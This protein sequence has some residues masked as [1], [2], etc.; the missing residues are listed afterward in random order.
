MQS[1]SSFVIPL[2]PRPPRFWLLKL[3]MVI[4]LIYPSWVIAMTVF[5]RLIRSS[6]VISSSS[7]PRDVFLSS[8]YLSRISLISSRITPRSSFS[9]ARIAFNSPI[10]FISSLYSF[11]IFSLS[12]PVK[13]LRRISTMAWAWTSVRPNVSISR[14]LASATFFD[15]RIM[16]ITSSIWSRA[17]NKPCKICARSSALF[18]SKRVLRVTTSSWCFR[19][20]SSICFRFRIIGWLLTSANMITPYVSC[21]WVCLYS[22]FSTTFGLASFFSSI[23]TRRP[24]R[25]DSSRR[26]EIPSIRLSFTSSAIFSMSFALLTI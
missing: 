22:W 21:S 18:N 24:S 12:R 3:S 11:S 19:Y 13:A 10:R 8:P 26:S 25:L 9:S 2:M 15:E 6:T 17:I 16:L 20:S 5:S 7:T 4:R 14:V 1:S 23:T